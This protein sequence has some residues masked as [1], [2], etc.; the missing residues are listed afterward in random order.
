MD[1]L[2]SVLYMNHKLSKQFVCLFMLKDQSWNGSP[3]PMQSRN[4]LKF[5]KSLKSSLISLF[6]FQGALLSFIIILINGSVDCLKEAFLQTWRK[7][8]FLPILSKYIFF[9]IK[10]FVFE[11]ELNC[12][13]FSAKPL[14]LS[15]RYLLF[16]SQ[17]TYFV[18]L[19]H[20]IWI[21]SPYFL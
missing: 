19:Y 3:T 2:L 20:I 15:P 18:L 7:N 5:W 14:T 4:L 12:S 6:C 1:H 8:F 21:Y 17:K 13:Q 11:N 9:D 10:P 16:S